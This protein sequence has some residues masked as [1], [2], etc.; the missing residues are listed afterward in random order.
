MSASVAELATTLML[1]KH[2]R[3]NYIMRGKTS[4][5]IIP[6][7]LLLVWL[8]T[9]TSTSNAQTQSAPPTHDVKFIV[10]S[11]LHFDP[12]R[13]GSFTALINSDFSH[14]VTA[15]ETN[16]S[17][18]IDSYGKQANDY[19]F[20]SSYF[21]LYSAITNMRARCP[22]AKFIL[23]TGD[24]VA[25]AFSTQCARA[26]PALDASSALIKCEAF[27]QFMFLRY[28]RCDAILIPVLGNNDRVQHNG[29]ITSNLL[30]AMA[31]MWAYSISTNS[32]VQKQFEATFS[33]NG[34][35][36][37]PL[38]GFDDIQLMEFDSCLLTDQVY[39]RNGKPVDCLPD[40][41]PEKTWIACH[42]PPGTD[43]QDGHLLWNSMALTSFLKAVKGLTTYMF[44]GHTHRD[45]FRL[46][47]SGDDTKVLI[48]VAPAVTTCYN[49]N[50]AYQIFRATTAG[51]ILD[52]ETIY[53]SNFP[54]LNE[55][56]HKWT[57]ATFRPS[58]I[59]EYNSRSNLACEYTYDAFRKFAHTLTQTTGSNYM[60]Y[61]RYFVVSS[62]NIARPHNRGPT[63]FTNLQRVSL[64]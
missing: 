13:S 21:L 61:S 11:D 41:F 5:A 45:E 2:D 37:L 40:S 59:T 29:I 44:C 39:L 1:K 47:Y 33:A 50:P 35:Y 46:T 25:H 49:N 20:D 55:K 51:T 36:I 15:F 18:V 53:L 10:A 12:F 9:S 58:W 57:W 14:W 54:E 7:S 23:L 42:I 17:N 30:S 26:R 56:P 27:V 31:K 60:N 16:R 34:R 52:Y 8:L 48:H 62:T 43:S 28:Y 63:S 6:E 19:Q 4:V 32:T 22:E 38:P 3:H 64:E 24:M